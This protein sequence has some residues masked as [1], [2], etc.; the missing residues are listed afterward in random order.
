MKPASSPS[1]LW[2]LFALDPETLSTLEKTL[3]RAAFVVAIVVIG[4]T[5]LDIRT[6]AGV[7][8]R[9]RVV[10]ARVLLAGYDPYTFAWQAGQP[11]ELLDPVHDAKAH[12]LTISPPTLL[13]YATLA[14]APY[15]FQRLFH[16]LAEW[17]A[18]IASLAL[19]ARSMPEQ[20]Q[21]LILVLGATCFVMATDIWRLHLE[22]GQIYVFHLL[23]LSVAIHCSRGGHVD[24][25]V[26]GVALGV[27]GL[28]RPNLLVFAPA[29]LLLRQ[30]RCG[31]ALMATVAI[32]GVVAF[33]VL[34]TE[35]WRSYLDVGDQYYRAIENPAALPD[36]PRSAPDSWAEGVDFDHALRNVESSSFAVLYQSL[37]DRFGLRNVD[38]ARA[39]KFALVILAAVLLMMAWRARDVGAGFAAMIV[40]GL[41]TEFFLPHRWGYADVMLLAPLAL[42]LPEVLRRPW[43]LGVIVIGLLSGPLGQQFFGLYAATVLRSWLVMGA[44]TAAV[45]PLT[46][47][48]SPPEGRGEQS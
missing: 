19:L 45:V 31:G 41:D 33:A 39:S 24:S 40:L 17:L 27:L 5:I 10:G 1:L 21:R 32:G 44:L 25:I 42:L 30:W 38:L 2:R 9:N 43:V 47:G 48:P 3:F 22:R 36:R 18:L 6:Y 16:F 4:W 29:L 35:S 28:M 15:A 8:L 12:R 11:E 46:P 26:A 23:A 7:D 37:R 14:P 34:P 13:L 20:R